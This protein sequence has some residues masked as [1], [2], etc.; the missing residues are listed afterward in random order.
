MAPGWGIYCS[1]KAAG[2]KAL[3]TV[4][5]KLA[6][7]RSHCCVVLL[8][9]R[10]QQCC[11]VLLS[12][13]IQQ[14]LRT[15]RFDAAHGSLGEL[16]QATLQSLKTWAGTHLLS[17]SVGAV[18]GIC[19]CTAPQQLLIQGQISVHDSLPCVEADVGFLTPSPVAMR[20]A[21]STVSSVQCPLSCLCL[22]CISSIL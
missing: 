20:H 9:S 12:P 4:P 13:C 2:A 17:E 14:V 5:P 3:P 6:E 1:P 19:T 11:V 10:T 21:G 18:Q 8:S 22:C 15:L 16:Q 7:L